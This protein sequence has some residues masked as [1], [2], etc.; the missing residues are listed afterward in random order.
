[1][2][3]LVVPKMRLQFRATNVRAIHR[4]RCVYLGAV[5]QLD[6][7]T[8]QHTTV[9]FTIFVVNRCRRYLQD[10]LILTYIS[11]YGAF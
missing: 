5:G 11:R 1:M 3:E 2:H 9:S 7:C 8:K 4:A 6:I 10:A